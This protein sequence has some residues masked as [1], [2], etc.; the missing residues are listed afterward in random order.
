MYQTVDTKS[1]QCK[2]HT[3]PNV[4]A[5]CVGGVVC[6]G[7][8]HM[9][10][11]EASGENACPSANDCYLVGKPPGNPHNQ[12]VSVD[13]PNPAFTSEIRVLK[14]QSEA[15]QG[16]CA[17]SMLNQ[18]KPSI[19]V[20]PFSGDHCPSVDDCIADNCVVGSDKT[21][22]TLNYLGSSGSEGAKSSRSQK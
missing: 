1:P 3:S 20:A 17:A 13:K 19:C 22:Q 5:I 10:L 8:E 2:P 9:A 16:L 15:N 4:N 6:N 11:C 7:V 14:I 18:G 12:V 21:P